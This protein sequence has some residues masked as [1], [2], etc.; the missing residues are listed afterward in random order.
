M[1]SIKDVRKTL[2][3]AYREILELE[4][5]VHD[6]KRRR[7]FAKTAYMLHWLMMIPCDGRMK[8]F[9]MP[10]YYTIGLMKQGKVEIRLS[11]V[12]QDG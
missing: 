12:V 8:N 3:K 9:V 2:H 10:D 5:D 11:E 4:Q 1:S 7:H 6:E